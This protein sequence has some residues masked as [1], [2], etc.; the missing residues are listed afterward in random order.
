[1]FERARRMRGHD[2]EAPD[3]TGEERA[4]MEVLLVAMLQD[5]IFV[6]VKAALDRAGAVAARRMTGTWPG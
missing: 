3:T 6:G 1:M 4:W 2:E 5:A